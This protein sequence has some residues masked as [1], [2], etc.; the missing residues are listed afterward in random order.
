MF[1]WS[2]A[3]IGFSENENSNDYKNIYLGAIVLLV[4]AII[5]KKNYI[6]PYFGIKY[7]AYL[8]ASKKHLYEFHYNYRREKSS[9]I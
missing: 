5:V 1:I 3:D 2:V 9:L 4:I 7:N 8:S 6:T